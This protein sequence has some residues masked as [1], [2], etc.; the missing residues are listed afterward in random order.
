M[1]IMVLIP[2]KLRPYKT[3]QSFIWKI[4]KQSL[5]RHKFFFILQCTCIFYTL[6]FSVKVAASLFLVISVMFSKC[7]IQHWYIDWV[8]CKPYLWLVQRRRGDCQLTSKWDVRIQRKDKIVEEIW[9]YDKWWMDDIFISIYQK[10]LFIKCSI[11]AIIFLYLWDLNS[12]LLST[13]TPL[14]FVSKPIKEMRW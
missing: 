4:C 11:S 13:G 3:I 12:W 14:I 6:S 10:D 1:F 5:S 7:L 8:S 9:I 2:K